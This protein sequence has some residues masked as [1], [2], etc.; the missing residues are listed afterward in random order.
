MEQYEKPM[1]FKVELI[2]QQRNI[3]HIFYAFTLGELTDKIK[4]KFPKAKIVSII[5]GGYDGM[6]N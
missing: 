3:T 5:G 6:Y 2:H 1:K 4:E